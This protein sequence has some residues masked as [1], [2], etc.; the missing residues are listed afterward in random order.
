TAM[1]K[2]NLSARAYDRILKVSRTVADLD[3]SQDISPSHIAE[4]IQYR[5]LDREGWLG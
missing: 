1:E 5:S 4:A 2:L 3:A